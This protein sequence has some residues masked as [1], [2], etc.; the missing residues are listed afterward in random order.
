MRN[1]GCRN[2]GIWVSQGKGPFPCNNARMVMEAMV[3]S[4]PVHVCALT[5]TLH[6]SS[7]SITAQHRLPSSD[8]PH[9]RDGS[10]PKHGLL[11]LLD[12]PL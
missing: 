3:R 7:A 12:P 10:R 6:L 11:S 5:H 9:H 4:E 2:V 1:K 8:I